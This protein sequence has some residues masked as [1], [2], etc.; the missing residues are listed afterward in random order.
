M[1]DYVAFLSVVDVSV[2]CEFKT[3]LFF[4]SAKPKLVDS[5]RLCIRKEC[6]SLAGV[7]V[8]IF[9]DVFHFDQSL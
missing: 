3:H 4:I 6:W 8:T 9:V 5:S 7:D 2:R 1:D